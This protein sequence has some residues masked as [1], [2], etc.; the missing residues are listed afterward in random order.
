MSAI[1]FSSG[2]SWHVKRQT[3]G[4]TG[5][6]KAL[7]PA[8]ER[9]PTVVA[10]E[11]ILLRQETEGAAVVGTD[12]AV[13]LRT[14]SNWRRVAFTDIDVA[15]WDPRHSRTVLK[16]WPDGNKG[17]TVSVPADRRF[18][19]FAAERVA[20]T[21]VVRRV[22]RLSNGAGAVLLVLREPGDNQLQWRV[23]LS[24]SDSADKELAREEADRLIT[25]F[26]WLVGS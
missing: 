14:E 12:R 20:S 21:Q 25:E 22:V 1:P 2:V 8:H 18:A 15:V 10:G 3:R 9:P 6:R 16:L 23:Q 24:C 7:R 4:K 5:L 11:R 17:A 19:A 13:H 26:R